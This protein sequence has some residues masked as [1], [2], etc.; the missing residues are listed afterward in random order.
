MKLTI[1]TLLISSCM[2]FAGPPEAPVPVN[3]TVTEPATL[4]KASELDVYLAGAGSW[5]KTAYKL[6]RYFGVD[7]AFGGSVGANYFITNNLGIGFDFTGYD[8]KNLSK[9]NDSSRRLV[10][11][12]LT[13]VTFRYPIGSFAPYVF[14]GAGAVFNGGNSSLV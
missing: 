14:V 6:D 4:F 13:R 9:A 5:T 7:H 2:A 1:L 3:Q 11:D 8:V 10:G 12:I